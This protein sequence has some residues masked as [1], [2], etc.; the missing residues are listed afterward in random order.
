MHD[1]TASAPVTSFF[2]R[3]GDRE[4]GLRAAGEAFDR[5][6]RL[7][8]VAQQA[9]VRLRALRGREQARE[10]GVRRAA[11][12]HESE[13]VGPARAE[14]LSMASA[15]TAPVRMAVI[16]LQSISARSSPL[17]LSKSIRSL[18]NAGVRPRMRET[19]F[20]PKRPVPL[21]EQAGHGGEEARCRGWTEIFAGSWHSCLSRKASR[22]HSTHCAGPM[23]RPSICSG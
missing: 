9:D 17:R 18:C 14:R 8:L 11:E 23:L 7:V 10:R 19:T 4:L 3:V 5:P 1:T 13:R 21:G 6:F 22:T 2:H 12:P 15:A 20:T 16:Q